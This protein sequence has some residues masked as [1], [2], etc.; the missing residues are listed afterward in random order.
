[1]NRA[2]R[3]RNLCEKIAFAVLAYAVGLS[4]GIM[5]GVEWMKHLIREAVK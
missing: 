3:E 1:M 2:E 4:T 5:I